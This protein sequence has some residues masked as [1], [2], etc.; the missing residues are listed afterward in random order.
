MEPCAMRSEFSATLSR[1]TGRIGVFPF[2]LHDKVSVI[3]KRT[4]RALAEQWVP[5]WFN[6]WLAKGVIINGAGNFDLFDKVCKPWTVGSGTT[7]HCKPSTD[8]QSRLV[9]GGYIRSTGRMG[10]ATQL[11]DGLERAGRVRLG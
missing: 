4:R 8:H 1:E 6:R 10:T 9:K 7:P 3:S 5:M 2:E 11:D